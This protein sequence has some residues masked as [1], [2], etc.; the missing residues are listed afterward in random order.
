[1]GIHVFYGDEPYILSYHRKAFE[2]KVSQEINIDF[3]DKWDEQIVPFVKT[4]PL[5]DAVR[6]AIVTCDKLSDVSLS[7]KEIADLMADTVAEL[8]VFPN[9]VDKRSKIYKLLS[10]KKVITECNKLTDMEKVKRLLLKEV[11]KRGGRVTEDALNLFLKRENYP[12]HEDVSLFNLFSDL[13]RL[14]SYNLDITADNVKKLIKE[15]V[16]EEVFGIAKMIQA[17]DPVGLSK[18]AAVA[19]KP[20]GTLSALLR[21]YRIAYKAKYFPVKDIGVKYAGLSTFSKEELVYGIEVITD[22]IAGIKN[23][24]MQEKNALKYCFWKLIHKEVA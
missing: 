5:F 4:C 15:N 2:G 13:D 3:F 6:V 11:S 16:S 19:S 7:E 24:S 1:M 18:Q 21:E 8:V 20:I 23:G 17:R 22:A 9:T 10:D 14:L 12:E